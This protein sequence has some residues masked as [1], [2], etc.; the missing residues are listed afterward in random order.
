MLDILS[1]YMSGCYLMSVAVDTMLNDD[2][3]LA[4]FESASDLV[5]H[6]L[7][8]LEVV[9]FEAGHCLSHGAVSVDHGGGALMLNLFLL[10]LLL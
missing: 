8:A 2:A 6:E 7:N 10:I 9:C 5:L 1:F 3:D 4:I